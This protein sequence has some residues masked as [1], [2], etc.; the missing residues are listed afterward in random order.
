MVKNALRL[1]V[2]QHR[3]I[4]YPSLLCMR[5]WKDRRPR[6]P[7]RGWRSS[8]FN[9]SIA[10]SD[11]VVSF[12][13]EGASIFGLHE[14]GVTFD[15]FL[16]QRRQNWC[17]QPLRELWMVGEVRWEFFTC[18]SC[19]LRPSASLLRFASSIIIII[20]A[21]LLL[22]AFKPTHNQNLTPIMMTLLPSPSSGFFSYL[23]MFFWWGGMSV[24]GYV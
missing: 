16:M 21:S 22:P 7:V 9:D 1:R 5:R 24:W 10:I 15:H 20:F 18:R 4:Y 12:A 8:D 3:H 6:R 19:I 13:A 2:Q 17:A 14:R 11:L 23:L